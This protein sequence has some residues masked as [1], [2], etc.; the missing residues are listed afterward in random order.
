MNFFWE[1]ILK[2]NKKFDLCTTRYLV[3]CL[4]ISLQNRP[5]MP[6]S[7][8]LWYMGMAI[9]LVG[10]PSIH[11][12]HSFSLLLLHLRGA[13]LNY[14]NPL[15]RTHAPPQQIAAMGEGT[16]FPRCCCC[17][18]WN[19][20]G[21]KGRSF[22]LIRAI[23]EIWEHTVSHPQHNSSCSVMVVPLLVDQPDLARDESWSVRASD[24]QPIKCNY[25]GLVASLRR[26]GLELHRTMSLGRL[27]DCLTKAKSQS[28]LLASSCNNKKL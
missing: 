15:H 1:I 20:G 5:K 6:S 19:V 17:L 25:L 9:C 28:S 10:S 16:N 26:G 18:D 27:T 4:R 22:I 11:P 24:Q 3:G 2:S 7:E 13:R 23:A 21:C 8:N 14:L 12:I